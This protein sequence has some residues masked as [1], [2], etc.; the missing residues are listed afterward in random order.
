MPGNIFVLFNFEKN[1][2]KLEKIQ[3]IVFSFRRF[4]LCTITRKL[5][6]NIYFMLRDFIFFIIKFEKIKDFF[7]A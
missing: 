4:G 5:F 2:E 7:P 1:Y 3:G 6:L